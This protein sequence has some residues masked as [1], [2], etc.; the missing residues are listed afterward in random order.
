MLSGKHE[1]MMTGQPDDLAGLKKL[2]AQL[3]GTDQHSTMMV[4]IGGQDIT[5]AWIES[6]KHEIA[7]LESRL[8]E[9]KA[10]NAARS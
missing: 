8:A 10:S 3:D 5:K 2:L 4:R 7:V 1:A 9:L 6:L